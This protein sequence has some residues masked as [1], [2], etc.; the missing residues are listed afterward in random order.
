MCKF[1]FSLLEMWVRKDIISVKT[2]GLICVVTFLLL[3]C[4]IRSLQIQDMTIFVGE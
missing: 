4:G 2:F 1:I 3:Y